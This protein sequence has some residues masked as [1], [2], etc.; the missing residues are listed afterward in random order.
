LGL[1]VEGGLCGVGASGW[2][3]GELDLGSNKEFHK[4]NTS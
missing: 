2:G 3:R 4:I 1:V